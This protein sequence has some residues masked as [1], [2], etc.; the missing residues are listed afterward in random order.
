VNLEKYEM[1]L[2]R[3]SIVDDSW[4]IYQRNKKDM[5]YGACTLP[6]NNYN[7]SINYELKD[8]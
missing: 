3:S 5:K 4:A 2:W 1:G 7:L 8:M 6:L